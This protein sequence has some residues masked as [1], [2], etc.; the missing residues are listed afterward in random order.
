MFLEFILHPERS[1]SNSNS[2]D[3]YAQQIQISH[4][5]RFLKRKRTKYFYMNNTY[6]LITPIFFF[7]FF[8]FLFLWPFFLIRLVQ[9]T[10]IIF[11][12]LPTCAPLP[13]TGACLIPNSLT[14]VSFHEPIPVRPAT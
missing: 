4:K 3:V 5:V 11:K 2:H 13:L 6:D 14:C 7:F 10:P 1:V 12:T 8:F 9:T